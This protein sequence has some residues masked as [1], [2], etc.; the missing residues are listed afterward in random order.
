MYSR[1]VHL[2]GACVRGANSLGLAFVL[3]DAVVLL[4]LSWEATVTAAEGGANIGAGLVLFAV[5]M[6][7]AGVW[8]AV[9][10]RQGVPRRALLTRWA[11]VAVLTGLMGPILGQLGE[12]F[13]LD[14]R[15]LLS[16]FA[17]VSPFVA[18]LIFAPSILGSDLAAGRAAR[19][20]GLGSV[21]S[22]HS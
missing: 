18:A 1:S 2:E 8:A 15:V 6:V 7:A 3:S 13:P 19:R 21:E 9:D 10:R 20:P 5:W 17:A 14:W 22:R 11:I 16:D 12:G 4:L